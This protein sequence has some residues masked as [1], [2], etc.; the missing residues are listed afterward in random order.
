[1]PGRQGYF[2]LKCDME[3]QL[4]LF[5]CESGVQ[6]AHVNPFECEFHDGKFLSHDI[7]TKNGRVLVN[8]RKSVAGDPP[9]CVYEPIDNSP[10]AVK[11][12]RKWIAEHGTGKSSRKRKGDDA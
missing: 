1:M 8:C 11:R 2:E 4:S 10:E 7:C 6:G 3:G 12:R 5:S 9:K